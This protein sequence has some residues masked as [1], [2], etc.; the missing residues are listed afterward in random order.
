[1][2][3]HI[4]LNRFRAGCATPFFTSALPTNSAEEPSF[5]WRIIIPYEPAESLP[6]VG[7]NTR[8]ICCPYPIGG[9]IMMI[10]IVFP[11]LAS[12]GQDSAGQMVNMPKPPWLTVYVPAAFPFSESLFP[13]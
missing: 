11:G 3:V 2:L 5:Y 6:T 9:T 7:L 1:V 4:S 8:K 13:A 12:A 10:S